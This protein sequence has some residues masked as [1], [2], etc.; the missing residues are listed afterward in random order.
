[1]PEHIVPH[2]EVDQSLPQVVIDTRK[3]SSSQ[4]NHRFLLFFSIVLT[5]ASALQGGWAVAD[6]GQ[7]AYVFAY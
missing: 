7:V 5:I 3:Q 6:S 1:M 4:V 2:S